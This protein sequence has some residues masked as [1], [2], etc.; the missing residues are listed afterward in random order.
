MKSP[1]SRVQGPKLCRRAVPALRLKGLFWSPNSR[2]GTPVPAK[3][4]LAL[5]QAIH[6]GG[7]DAR[8]RASIMEITEISLENLPLYHATLPSPLTG[9]TG[10]APNPPLPA[11]CAPTF[12]AGRRPGA[13]SP[14]STGI[15]P[16]ETL[17]FHLNLFKTA[18][19]EPRFFQKPGKCL[20]AQVSSPVPHLID[21]SDFKWCAERTLQ[22]LFTSESGVLTWP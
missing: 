20:V 22:K 8:A 16:V 19:P 4:C 9:S 18:A 1:K 12:L 2:L 13:W 3:L 5:N 21:R 7:R 11:A 10:R 17:L 15:L 6:E 14:G